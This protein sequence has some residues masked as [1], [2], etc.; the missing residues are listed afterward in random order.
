MGR[1]FFVDGVRH[2]REPKTKIELENVEYSSILL[3]ALSSWAL[4]IIEN[5]KFYSPEVYERHRQQIEHYFR[6]TNG[7]LIDPISDKAEFSARQIND[8]PTKD[9]VLLLN[10]LGVF[11]I[12]SIKNLTTENK[13]KLFARLL[14][15]NEKNVTE[16]IRNCDPK[17]NR[18]AAD[19]PYIYANKVSSINQLLAS[20]GFF[21]KL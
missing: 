1:Y 3:N 9:Q 15:R 18:Q 16:C 20:L 2:Y 21:T 11:D 13:G 4:K 10:E 12:P 14:N 5:V 19:N 17:G 7:L 6:F 8:T